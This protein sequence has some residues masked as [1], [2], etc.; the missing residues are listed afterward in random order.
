MPKLPFFKAQEGIY[1]PPNVY[2]NQ[3]SGLETAVSTL[4][5]DSYTITQ[6]F[7]INVPH[8]FLFFLRFVAE[9]KHFPSGRMHLSCIAKIE[10]LWK[11]N[12]T[13]VTYGTGDVSTPNHLLISNLGGM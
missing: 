12:V 13:Q 5:Y 2:L 11:D 4:R 10:N 7:S 9:T 8:F 3:T 6:P 1:L